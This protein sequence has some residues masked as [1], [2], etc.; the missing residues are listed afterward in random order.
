MRR[1][2][3]LSR[4]FIDFGGKFLLIGFRQQCGKL[5]FGGDDERKKINTV[6]RAAC[7]RRNVKLW[8]SFR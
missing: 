3:D 2:P 6:G 8:K 4:I 7:P 1:T 5:E